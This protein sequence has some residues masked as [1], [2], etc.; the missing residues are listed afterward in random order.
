MAAAVPIVIE[1]TPFT[2]VECDWEDALVARFL[3]AVRSVWEPLPPVVKTVFHWYV[4]KE[5]SPV[6]RLVSDRTRW[7]GESGWAAFVPKDR[8]LWVHSSPFHH[9]SDAML[10]HA[11]IAHEL[12]HAIFFIL[13]EHWHQRATKYPGPEW[14]V[15][16]L[17]KRWGYDP[18]QAEAWR[19]FL[20]DANPRLPERTP[21]MPPADFE[22]FLDEWRT[23]LAEQASRRE[24]FL[25]EKAP[26]LKFA[27]GQ[28]DALRSRLAEERPDLLVKVLAGDLS[29]EAALAMPPEGEK[30]S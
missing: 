17:Q 7:G 16:A 27:G 24:A 1:C 3:E 9:L 30:R 12:A 19:R 25:V 14:L 8:A 11:G 13:E 5:S 18:E 6:I 20:D 10:L 4:G 15:S 26:Y 23:L 29:V 28:A 2:I 21:P 22:R